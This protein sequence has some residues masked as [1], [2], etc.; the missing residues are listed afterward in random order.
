MRAVETSEV[1]VFMV[2]KKGMV[3]KATYYTKLWT[4]LDKVD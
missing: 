2:V 4:L 3:E 1:Q